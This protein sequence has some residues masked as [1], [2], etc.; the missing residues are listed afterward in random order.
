MMSTALGPIL[1]WVF[2]RIMLRWLAFN[3]LDLTMDVLLGSGAGMLV[4]NCSFFF[5][6][7]AWMRNNYQNAN[8]HSPL[9]KCITEEKE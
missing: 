6:W 5:L 2:G 4:G 1:L 3:G 7:R 9:D 8:L